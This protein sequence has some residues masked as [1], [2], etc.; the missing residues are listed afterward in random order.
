MLVSWR[1]APE[2]AGAAGAKWPRSVRS[3]SHALPRASAGYRAYA[4]RVRRPC[5]PTARLRPR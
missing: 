2:R 5:P 4:P 1:P 3:C